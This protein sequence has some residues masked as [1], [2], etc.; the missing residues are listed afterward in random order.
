MRSVGSTND[1]GKKYLNIAS[2]QT[3]SLGNE[4]RLSET[5][6]ELKKK[7]KRMCSMESTSVQS[8]FVIAGV[9]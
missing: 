4:S 5:G 9:A 2:N 3:N 6:N 1:K 7:R 8:S